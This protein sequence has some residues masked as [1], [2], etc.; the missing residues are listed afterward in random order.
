[1]YKTIFTYINGDLYE[2]INVVE[3]LKLGHQAHYY[4]SSHP[5]FGRQNSTHFRWRNRW[6]SHEPTMSDVAQVALK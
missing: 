1:M 2:S 3:Q 5:R 6:P 4:N